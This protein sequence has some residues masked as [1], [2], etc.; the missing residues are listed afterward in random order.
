MQ[1]FHR[2]AFYLAGTV[3]LIATLGLGMAYAKPRPKKL[4]RIATMSPADRAPTRGSAFTLR[5]ALPSTP[6]AVKVL[7]VR[8]DIP[9]KP[10]L[11][12]LLEALPYEDPPEVKK[13]LLEIAQTL[14]AEPDEVLSVPIGEWTI[15]VFKGGAYSCWNDDR[16]PDVMAKGQPP[17]AEA[18]RA[19]A[20]AFLTRAGMAL[21]EGVRFLE[22][23]ACG[24]MDDTPVA[25]R[26]SYGGAKID[27][28]PVPGGISVEVVANLQL[29]SVRNTLREMVP[30]RE[31]PILSPRE[32][33]DL[34]CQ[35]KGF[36]N[37]TT[38][39]PAKRSVDSVRLVYWQPPIAVEPSYVVPIYVFSGVGKNEGWPDDK[40]SAFVEAIRPEYLEA[41]FPMRR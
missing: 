28:L 14:E 41:Q 34:L 16:F 20:D 8:G 4:P 35:G 2:Q 6:A 11:L 22:V 24:W 15:H 17:K 33:F 21:P 40:W 39:A 38:V 30:D 18:V 3:I 32:A 37:A 25:W 31:V 27:G 10:I 26:A 19:I 36:Y 12:K 13:A 1:P 9:R 7:K 5:T 23:K 29:L